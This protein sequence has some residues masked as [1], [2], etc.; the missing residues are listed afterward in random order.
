MSSDP[1][2]LYSFKKLVGMQSAAE[3]CTCLVT[4][5][6]GRLSEYGTELSGSKKSADILIE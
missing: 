4:G 2:Q 3:G 5:T 1:Y 6:D